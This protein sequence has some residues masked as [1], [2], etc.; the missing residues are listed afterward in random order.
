[1]SEYAAISNYESMISALDRFHSILIT[2]S[3][4]MKMAGNECVENMSG[5]T[6]AAKAN[7]LLQSAVGGF[8]DITV[9]VQKLIF[10]MGEELE[11]MKRS[12]ID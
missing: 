1:M 11:R 5:D 2:Q 10:N 12:Q 7:E 3:G 8:E 9:R 4:L 6:H